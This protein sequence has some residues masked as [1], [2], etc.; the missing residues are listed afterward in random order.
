MWN[1]GRG[2]RRGGGSIY[3]VAIFS[4]ISNTQGVVKGF[5]GGFDNVFAYTCD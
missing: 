5:W 3:P 2:K 1:T 4:Y